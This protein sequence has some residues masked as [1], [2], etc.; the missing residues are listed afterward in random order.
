MQGLVERTH[1]RVGSV[2]REQVLDEIVGADAQ[3][4]DVLGEEVGG[5]GGAR[6]FDSQAD[7]Q[8]LAEAL[9]LAP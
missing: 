6:H 5:E 9:A 8:V 1:P 2:D 3:E 4:I 7:R